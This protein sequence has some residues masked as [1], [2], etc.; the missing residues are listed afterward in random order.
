ME[1]PGETAA[2]VASMLATLAGN[3][4]P[5]SAPPAGAESARR[6]NFM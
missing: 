4:Q 2:V 1:R 6:M 3:R 5:P